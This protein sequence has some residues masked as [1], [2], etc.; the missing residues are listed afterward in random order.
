MGPN[1]PDHQVY[2]AT[3]QVLTLPDAYQVNVELLRTQSADLRVGFRLTLA[4]AGHV[5][6]VASGVVQAL[7]RTQPDPPRVGPSAIEVRVIDGQER[8]VVDGQVRIAIQQPGG[9]P[10]TPDAPAA[11]VAGS[12]GLYRALARF[13]A[14]GPWLLIITVDRANQPTTKLRTS[15]DVQGADPR[16]TLT[17]RPD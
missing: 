15:L 12:P 16:P 10:A 17:A 14:S 6:L 9:A 11:P 3:G 5:T 7:V 1:D 13:T 4:P 8:P 2:T